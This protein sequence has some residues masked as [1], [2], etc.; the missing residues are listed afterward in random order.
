MPEE[1]LEV[2]APT[3]TPAPEATIEDAQTFVMLARETT[4]DLLVHVNALLPCLVVLWTLVIVESAYLAVFCY[5]FVLV[6]GPLLTLW[7]RGDAPS[8]A[9]T[10]KKVSTLGRSLS[11]P[12]EWKRCALITTGSLC[13]VGFGGFF[14]YLAALQRELDDLGITKE[15]KSGTRDKGLYRGTTLRDGAL[16]FLGV[17]F[18]TVNPV[19]EELFWRGYCYAE[20]GRTLNGRPPD[21]SGADASLN[22]DPSD[23]DDWKPRSRNARTRRALLNASEQTGFSRWLTSVYFGSFHGVVVHVFVGW[24]VAL[25]CFGALALASRVW[26]WLG[27]R[28]PFGFP[29]VVAFHAGADVAVVLIVSA[30][31]FGWTYEAAYVVA[32]VSCGLLACCGAGLLY[33]AWRNESFP[34]VPCAGGGDDDDLDAALARDLGPGGRIPMP[35]HRSASGSVDIQGG[36]V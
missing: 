10:R 6:A 3:A 36:I 19:L 5:E 35:T 32:L 24:E 28:A 26:I 31:D 17:W 1:P 9:A 22:S 29:F 7:L 33:V 23:D 4:L 13:V 2:T 8:A 11:R 18:C 30:C 21:D 15:I 14:V 25:L 16:L 27:E 34:R 12:Y 20:V